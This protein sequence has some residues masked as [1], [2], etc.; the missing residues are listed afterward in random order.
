MID[1]YDLKELNVKWLRNSFGV[2]GQEPVLFD[3]TIAQNIRFGDAEADIEKIISAAKK[4]NAHDFIMKLPNV[5]CNFK[6]NR[7]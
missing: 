6:F 3:T 4:A 2:V 7:L 1:G 5:S